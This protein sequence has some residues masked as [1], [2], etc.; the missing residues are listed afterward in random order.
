MPDDVRQILDRSCRDCHT[1]ETR[2]PWY[3]YLQPPASF[4]AA[5]IDDGRR[6][7]NFSVWA[8]YDKSR[9]R[10]KLDEICR[11]A[12]ARAMPL[13]SYLWIH[14]AARLSDEEIRALCR[15]TEDES[16]RLA[17]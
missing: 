2:L 15:W 14:R 9:R 10:R 13:P 6:E 7:L 8:T 1:N 3:S 5:H 17:E 4:L 12:E 16:A 11:E